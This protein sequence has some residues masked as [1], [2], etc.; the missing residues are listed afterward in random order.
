MQPCS[1]RRRMPPAPQAATPRPPPRAPTRAAQ[2]RGPE[3]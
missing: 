2:Q 1:R 3:P